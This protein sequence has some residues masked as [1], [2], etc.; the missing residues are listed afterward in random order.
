MA[1]TATIIGTRALESED[2]AETAAISYR[3]FLA[4]A[5]EEPEFAAVLLSLPDAEG[6]LETALAPQA[7]RTLELGIEQGR[8]ISPTSNWRSRRWRPPRSRRCARASP[9]GLG[10]TPRCTAP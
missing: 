3:R 8:L 1:R 9:A 5:T 2:P 4:Y 10:P 7:R 6:V